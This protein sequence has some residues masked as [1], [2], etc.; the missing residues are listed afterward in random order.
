[1]MINKRLINEMGDTKK[2]IKLQVFLQWIALLCNIVMVFTLTSL[3]QKAING[4]AETG[5]IIKTAIISIVVMAI[6]H[7][8][9]YKESVCSGESS[10][11]VKSKLRHMIYEKLL[12]IGDKYQDKFSTSEILQVSAE[13]VEQLEIYFSKYLP[14][15][16]YSLLAPMTL[17]V[18]V[19]FMSLKTAFVLFICVPLIPISIIR[20][21]KFAKKL[22]A[23]YWGSYVQLGDHFLDNMQGLTTLKVYQSDEFKNEEMNVDAENF[24]RITMKVLTMQLNSVTLMDLIA[25]GGSA[26]G[27]VF[28]SLEF[29][30]G[31][32]DFSQALA[33][34]L[35]SAEFFIPLRLLGSFFHIAM[36]GMAAS[37][38]MFRL[39]DMEEDSNVEKEY[40]N[41]VKEVSV[42]KNTEDNIYISGE[43]IEFGYEEGKNVIR[44]ISFE[45]PKNSFVSI[46]GESG[47]GKSTLASILMG[48]NKINSGKLSIKNR[49]AEEISTDEKMKLM[50]MVSFQNYLFKGTVRE[51]LL[52]G[53]DD[54]KDDK[55]LDALKSVNLYEFFSTLEGL[56]TKIAEQASNLSG[57]QRQRLCIARALLHDSEI[58][59]FDEATSNIDVESEEI[60]V[61]LIKKLKREK[62]VIQIT[63]RL[64]NVVESDEIYM[65]DSGNIIEKGTHRELMERKGQYEKMYTAQKEL[66]LY[67]RE[68][69]M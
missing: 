50:T 15:L 46:V 49:N 3:L 29:A 17:F 22:L 8:V 12:K 52:M 69:A 58:Y 6:R 59:I 67:V 13:G 47:C 56:D 5:E 32:I 10:K 57:G 31:N 43:N 33:I 36:N 28:A 30:Q 2:Y 62:T 39:I 35:L 4:G 11:V 38:K 1:M 34:I 23:K 44:G 66:E 16:F 55:L 20:I 53:R 14:Q 45:I 41:N 48:Y 19:S 18:L 37:E 40:S 27:V 21:Q 61:D 25:Y 24:R 60:I 42:D 63:H 51:N 68:E 9:M 64:A 26:L 7:I 54:I 65:M